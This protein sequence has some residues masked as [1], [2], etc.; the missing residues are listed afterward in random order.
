[1]AT[2]QEI[3]KLAAAIAE[4][5]YHQF[6]VGAANSV[7]PQ[8]T[9]PRYDDPEDATYRKIAEWAR[10]LPKRD[11]EMLPLVVGRAK[12][13][14][15]LNIGN[16]FTGAYGIGPIDG[17]Q[18]LFQLLY[19]GKDVGAEVGWHLRDLIVDGDY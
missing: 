17:E 16:I 12:S 2:E 6:V 18:G 15:L 11:Q 9:N 5:L 14:L 10:T 13:D 4:T 1:M 7:L 19:D 8:W 3:E